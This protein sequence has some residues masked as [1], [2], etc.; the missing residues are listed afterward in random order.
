M[1]HTLQAA[2]KREEKLNT[3]HAKI[4]EGFA[5]ND[6]KKK[7]YLCQPYDKFP[8]IRNCYLEAYGTFLAQ[9]CTIEHVSTATL[10][11]G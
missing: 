1:I 9:C 10:Y 5:G 6:E 8:E 7:E 11:D 4:V 3:L 2:E